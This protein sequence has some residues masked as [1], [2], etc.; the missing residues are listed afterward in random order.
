MRQDDHYCTCSVHVLCFDVQNVCR[1]YHRLEVIPW[2]LIQRKLSILAL[3]RY[4]KTA[5]GE[6]LIERVVLC[7]LDPL[8]F[9]ATVPPAP[10]PSTKTATIY[11][12]RNAIKLASERRCYHF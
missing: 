12:L 6:R 8:S 11:G 10:S 9:A 2:M 5:R 1:V 4:T 3:I 7:A